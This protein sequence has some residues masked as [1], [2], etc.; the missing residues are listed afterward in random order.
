MLLALR[1]RRAAPR[2]ER[3]RARRRGRR[4]PAVPGCMPRSS[5]RRTWGRVPESASSASSTRPAPTPARPRAGSPRSATPRTTPGRTTPTTR[6]RAATSS[7]T[8]RGRDPLPRGGRVINLEHMGLPFDRTPDGRIY[9]RRFGG[10]TRDYGRGTRAAGVPRRRPHR[11]HDPPDALP[12]VHQAGRHVLRRVPHARPHHGRRRVPRDRR[13]R[14]RHGRAARLPR[15]ERPARHRRVRPDVQGLVERLR[16]D[17]RRPGDR[18]PPRPP[19]R[20]HGVL[21][22]PPDGDLPAGHPAVRGLPRRRRR[23][24][25]RR[26]ASASWSAT[27]RTSRTSPAATSARGRSTRKSPRAGGSAARTTSTST[28]AIYGDRRRLD[29]KLPDIIDFVRTYLGVDPIK[30]PMP[31][32]PTAHYAM[33]G[34]PTDIHGRVIRDAHGPS[35]PASTRR[36]SA[37][38]S[39]S[40]GANR[41]GTNSLVD[42]V[43]YGRRSGRAMAR[44][45]RDA[46]SPSGPVPP[47]RSVQAM[48]R[49]L[50]AASEA[51]AGHD[52]GRAAGGDVHECG[53]FRTEQPLTQCRDEVADLKERGATCSSEDKGPLQY[54]PAEPRA[55]LPARLAE[56]TVGRPW[57]ATKAA[58]PTR[59]RTSRTAT[60]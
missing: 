18:L 5:P 52:P 33:G 8:R 6:S 59:V 42:L 22:V 32:Q 13:H 40:H 38:A 4:A 46:P 9:Q 12:A 3:P 25:Q 21:P 10:H 58:E 45:V 37:P 50:L 27:P 53:V 56:A 11:A 34:L 49:A 55:R 14:D 43:V 35:S 1:A 20:G 15:Q 30:E 19:A 2:P 44:H 29:K 26:R 31:I 54:R 51:S 7:S 36:A 24:V 57:P 47:R 39:A 48:V 60:T 23:D 28:S 17:R 41:L 16:P